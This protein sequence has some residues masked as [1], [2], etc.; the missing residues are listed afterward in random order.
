MTNKV[1]I[2]ISVDDELP[3]EDTEV[4][5]FFPNHEHGKNIWSGGV[6]YDV[7]II[8][9]FPNSTACYF[10][11]S[12]WLKEVELPTNEDILTSKH[13]MDGN[14]GFIEGANFVLNLL[15]AK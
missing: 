13:K 6:V 1:F 10:Q 8:S 12:H 9:S 3:P 5:A 14:P 15:K 7:E 11:A 2:P 4:W